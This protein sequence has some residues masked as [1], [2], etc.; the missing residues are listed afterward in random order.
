MVDYLRLLYPCA[1]QLPDWPHALYALEWCARHERDIL[2]VDGGPRREI[3]ALLYPDAL[4]RILTL[5]DAEDS[6]PVNHQNINELLLDA[7]DMPSGT[8]ELYYSISR[9]CNSDWYACKNVAFMCALL[10]CGRAR[11]DW[12]FPYG[13]NAPTWLRRMRSRLRE[14]GHLVKYRRALSATD[15][16][17]LELAGYVPNYMKRQGL[18]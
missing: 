17:W 15:L 2:G 5:I 1:T 13:D 8:T 10:V 4:G 18:W 16:A 6:S 3:L 11:S 14:L 7:R 9:I 12:R